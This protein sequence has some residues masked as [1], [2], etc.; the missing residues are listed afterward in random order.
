MAKYKVIYRDNKEEIVDAS[1]VEVTSTVVEF[2]GYIDSKDFSGFGLVLI[3]PCD[4][5]AKIKLVE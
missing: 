5:V 4:R 2:T 1:N 3:V